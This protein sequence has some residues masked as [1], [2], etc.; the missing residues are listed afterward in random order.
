MLD[1]PEAARLLRKPVGTVRGYI[2]SRNLPATLVGKSYLIK[3]KELFEWFEGMKTKKGP[4]H[5]STAPVK[6]M[7]SR[8]RFRK[9]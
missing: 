4:T 9:C 1:L 8:H 2:H 5:N 6:M 7:A 3:Y